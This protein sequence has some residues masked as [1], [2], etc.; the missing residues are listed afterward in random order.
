VE[1]GH[2]GDA[3]QRVRDL[4]PTSAERTPDVPGQMRRAVGLMDTAQTLAGGAEPWWTASTDSPRDSGI[5]ALLG[6]PSLSLERV[7]ASSESQARSTVR[8]AVRTLK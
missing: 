1:P 8:D 7:S 4:P 2:L 5:R 6:V 3:A